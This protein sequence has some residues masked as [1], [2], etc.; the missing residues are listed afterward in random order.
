MSVIVAFIVGVVAVALARAL[1][2]SLTSRNHGPLPPGPKR[3]PIIGNLVRPICIFY[4][5]HF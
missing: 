1:F 2:Q 4:A 5:S 3:L